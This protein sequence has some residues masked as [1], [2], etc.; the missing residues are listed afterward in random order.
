[1][2]ATVLCACICSTKWV[3]PKFLPSQ[4]NLFLYKY[5]LVYTLIVDLIHKTKAI[6]NNSKQD[7]KL[8]YECPQSIVTYQFQFPSLLYNAAET[9]YKEKKPAYTGHVIMAA[10]V[11]Y[12]R[13]LKKS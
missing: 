5:I 7:C 8:L 13:M 2:K 6:L 1:M 9:I 4:C 10:I 3:V 12:S 11:F